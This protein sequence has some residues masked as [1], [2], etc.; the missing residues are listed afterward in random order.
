MRD[1][2]KGGKRQCIVKPL[3]FVGHRETSGSRAAWRNLWPFWGVGGKGG[4]GQRIVRPLAFVGY[5]ET[6]GGRVHG[7]TFGFWRFSETW[8][9]F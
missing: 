5:R 3:A 9:G 6:W 8:G 7:E 2:G 1:G 4:S